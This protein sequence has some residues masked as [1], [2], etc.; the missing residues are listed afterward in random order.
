MCCHVD[1][2]LTLLLDIE[3]PLGTRERLPR[4]IFEEVVYAL[5]GDGGIF[6][7]TLLQLAE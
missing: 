1:D 2:A 7:R 3:V 4:N 5:L 6:G